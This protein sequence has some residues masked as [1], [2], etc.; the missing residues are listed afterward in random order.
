LD[1]EYPYLNA[2]GFHAQQAAEKFLKAY[3]TSIEVEFA[4]SHS[5]EYLLELMALSHPT[6]A[7]QLEGA[8]ALTQYGVAVRYPGDLPDLSPPQAAEAVALARMVAERMKLLLG[9]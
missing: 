5:I 2:I 1:E 7:E 6:V 9:G 3:L 8:I 4:K